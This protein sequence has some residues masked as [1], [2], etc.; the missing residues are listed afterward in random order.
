MLMSR[1]RAL[2]PAIALSLVPQL[3]P[4]NAALAAPKVLVD[5]PLVQGL[6]RSVMGEDSDVEV[7]LPMDADPHHYAMKP[8]DVRKLRQ[9]EIV[10]WIGPGLTPWLEPLLENWVDEA[11]LLELEEA[12]GVKLL[13]RRLPSDLLE[14]DHDDHGDEEHAESEHDDHDDHSDEGHTD[15]EHD[16]HDDHGEDDHAEGEHDDHDDHNKEEHGEDDHG[17]HG[18]E[19]HAHGAFDPHIWFG[20]SNVIEMAKAI[21]EKLSQADP[22]NAARYQEN[23]AQLIDEINVVADEISTRMN[24]VSGTRFLI[25]HDAIQYFETHTGLFASGIILDSEDQPPSAARLVA[26]RQAAAENPFNCVLL[27]PGISQSLAQN[28]INQDDAHIVAIDPLGRDVEGAAITG[29]LRNLATA[30]ETCAA[31]K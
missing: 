22:D 28:A 21:R 31:G 7:L 4:V 14:H 18:H 15:G 16:D 2:A 11:G 1:L 10:I 24:A 25:G 13:E 8:S 26:L 19:G 12:P 27:E 3:L 5:L 29:I 20:P 17:D 6:V 9:A 23:T 30:I